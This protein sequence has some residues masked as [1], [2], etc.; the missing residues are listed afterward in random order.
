[1]IEFQT[2]DLLAADAEALVNTVNCVGVMG[3]GVALQFK[4]AY[5]DNFA[6]Y[7]AVCARGE[8][9]PGD[10]FVT[11]TRQLTNPRFILNVATKDHWRGDSRLEWVEK[12]LVG[13]LAEI[14]RRNIKSIAIPPLG[15]G[16][17]GLE[18]DVVRP[19]IARMLSAVPDVRAIV[20]EPKGAPEPALM[21][22]RKDAPNM[23]PGRATLIAL[24]NRYLA[25]F[26]DPSVT[27]LEIHK[28]M[29]FMQAAGQPLRLSFQEALYGPYAENLRHVLNAIEGW[30]IRGY[31]DGGDAPD[32]EVEL[33]YDF[34][35][36]AMTIIDSDPETKARFDRVADLVNGFETPFGMELLATTHW[37]AAHKG[38]RT[39]EEAIE[40]VHNW[41]ER[42]AQFD[43]EQ[44]RLAWR[45]LHDQG[46]L[47]SAH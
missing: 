14:R 4:K 3:R 11:E 20:F 38:A 21:A 29:Y 16:L 15:C 37:V 10:V 46:W 33:V 12:G 13:I 8:L 23:T 44:I 41:N 35:P 34:V 24:A 43:G 39:A 45:T 25:G 2:G 30:F 32:K 6:A 36:Q 19:R 42:K 31:S 18:W 1:M 47:A 26:M 22:K 27:L 7:E 9:K 17:G 40:L 5:P 28:L